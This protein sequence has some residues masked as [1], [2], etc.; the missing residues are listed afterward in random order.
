LKDAIE[1]I[2][3]GAKSFNAAIEG[4]IGWENLIKGVIALKLLDTAASLGAVAVAIG[5]V[6]IAAKALP[7]IALGQL[8]VV[9]GAGHAT[10]QGFRL[11]AREDTG[12][13]SMKR[14][15]LAR[16][17]LVLENLISNTSDPKRRAELEAKRDAVVKE[18]DALSRRI[19]EMTSAGAEKGIRDFAAKN[20]SG[21]GS[22]IG[23]SS[24][25]GGGGGGS[26]GGA[27]G[28]GIGSGGGGMGARGGASGASPG[29]GTSGANY[30]GGPIPTAADLTKFSTKG[31]QTVT[32][33]KQAAAAMKGFL[34]DLEEA[35][36]P[37]GSI[38][39]HNVRRIAGSGKMSQHAYGNA[40]DVGSQTGRDIVSP[41][42][43]RWVKEN[44]E[45]L[46]RLTQK[47]SI[48]DGSKFRSPDLGHFEWN[49]RLGDATKAAREAGA[50]PASRNPRPTSIDIGF[51]APPEARTNNT[52]PL[53][54]QIEMNRGTSMSPT[55]SDR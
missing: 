1:S 51:G 48:V 28:G 18:I 5:R 49:P 6:S 15:E 53:F 8:A 23:G 41:A 9:A 3:S 13:L 22:S 32:V 47:W 33:N 16:Q 38:G 29:G 26:P 2:A 25:F 40:V 43:A 52:V 46:D 39:S 55:N 44:R 12:P 36:A 45:K 37:L 14:M 34:S 31:G 10:I 24:P 30:M 11:G 7:L 50:T 35:G 21:L 54:R 42:F 4:S 27:P 19:E 20:M 17:R